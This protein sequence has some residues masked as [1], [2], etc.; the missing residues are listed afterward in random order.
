MR[1]SSH[2]GLQFCAGSVGRKLRCVIKSA[3]IVAFFVFAAFHSWIRGDTEW[4]NS[5][6]ANAARKGFFSSIDVSGQLLRKNAVLGEV[7]QRSLFQEEADDRVL[8]E[9]EEENA[10]DDSRKYGA[11][12]RVS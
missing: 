4:S 7:L 12:S 8:L 2:E 10:T 5:T 9:E 1:T 11:I 6:V 3:V